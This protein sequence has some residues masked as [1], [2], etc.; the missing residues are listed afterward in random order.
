MS[1][2]LVP[3]NNS[4]MAVLFGKASNRLATRI[5]SGESKRLETSKPLTLL[6]TNIFNH[7]SLGKILSDNPTF[8]YSIDGVPYSVE[9]LTQ[10][11]ANFDRCMAMIEMLNESY[12]KTMLSF[13]VSHIDV[14]PLIRLD[15]QGFT[16]GYILRM[17]DGTVEP[18]ANE[19]YVTVNGPGINSVRVAVNSISAIA[20]ESA[21]IKDDNGKSLV[22]YTSYIAGGP[23]SLKTQLSLFQ[24]SLIGLRVEM[25]KATQAGES[26]IIKPLFVAIKSG[27]A[28]RENYGFQGYETEV[29]GRKGEA[30]YVRG[31]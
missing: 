9:Q 13:G 30:S 24:Q 8:V 19:S 5:V 22:L 2:T 4:V 7:P 11:S 28:N 16:E 20:I 29:N 14:A 17:K 3:N 31:K 21:Q 23:G 6:A 10:M 25:E 26:F 1:N 27:K 15:G 12:V 18:A